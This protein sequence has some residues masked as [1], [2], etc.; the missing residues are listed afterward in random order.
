VEHKREFCCSEIPNLTIV[1]LETLF[2]VRP[3][4][5]RG[6]AGHAWPLKMWVIGCP[7]TSIT[8]NL[9]CVASQEGEERRRHEITTVA[10]LQANGPTDDVRPVDMTPEY[11]TSGQPALV[12]P[13]ALRSGFSLGLPVLPDRHFSWSDWKS[14]QMWATGCSTA[15]Q[16]VLMVCPAAF[17]TTWHFS[18]AQSISHPLWN[19]MAERF[20]SVKIGSDESDAWRRDVN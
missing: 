19:Q 14:E 13:T 3:G 17:F 18:P 7:E 11:L 1:S 2:I 5:V 12:V 4:R 10:L 16:T 15:E 8:T 6:Q 9:R 20:S